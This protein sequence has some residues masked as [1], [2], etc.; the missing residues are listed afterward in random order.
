MD[1]ISTLDFKARCIFL[2]SVGLVFMLTSLVPSIATSPLSDPIYWG[3]CGSVLDAETGGFNIL[4]KNP[5]K[6][7][8]SVS[9]R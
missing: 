2:S 1:L 5:K 3:L 7:E 9:L 6:S 8:Q 4:E